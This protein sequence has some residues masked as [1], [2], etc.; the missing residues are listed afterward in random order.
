MQIDYLK[1]ERQQPPKE[2]AKQKKQDQLQKERQER[3]MEERKL[4]AKEKTRQYKQ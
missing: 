1:A 4:Q 2:I 3:E